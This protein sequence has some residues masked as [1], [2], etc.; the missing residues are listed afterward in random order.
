MLER[1]LKIMAIALGMK[2][3][4]QMELNEKIHYDV[5]IVNDSGSNNN[6]TDAITDE[7]DLSNEGTIICKLDGRVIGIFPKNRTFLTF[8]KVVED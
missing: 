6:H 4:I 5:T 2:R 3:G 7:I 8:K 1:H